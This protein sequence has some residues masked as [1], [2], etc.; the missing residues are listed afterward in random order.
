MYL[1]KLLLSIVIFVLCGLTFV[2]ISDASVESN[3]YVISTMLTVEHLREWAHASVAS[4]V[5]D[6]NLVI[7]GVLLVVIVLLLLKQH[8]PDA[9]TLPVQPN[10]V[11]DQSNLPAVVPAA[12]PA[13]VSA[14]APEEIPAAVPAALPTAIPTDNVR[15]V[16]SSA[17]PQLNEYN[18]ADF[19]LRM[20]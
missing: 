16:R 19:K 7:I 15:F 10:C 17:V 18:F 9:Q 4:V 12:I 11:P 6:T 1:N 8:R 13:A 5:P 2:V 14:S 3:E 20:E